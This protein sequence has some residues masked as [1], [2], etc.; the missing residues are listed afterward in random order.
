MTVYH[1][2]HSFSPPAPLVYV[3]LRHPEQEIEVQ[4][5]PAQVD[6]GSDRTIVPQRYIEG[7]SV[8]RLREIELVGF[9]NRVY[10]TLTYYLHVAIKGTR[11]V[12]LEVATGENETLVLVGRDLLN[13]FKVVLDGPRLTLEISDS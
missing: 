3:T 2:H 5:I 7:L 12:P 13:Q 10:R 6:T 4:D 8:V 1:Y 11:L 9:E